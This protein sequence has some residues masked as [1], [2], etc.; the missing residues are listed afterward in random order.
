MRK[1]PKI[2][3]LR[4]YPSA[5]LLTSGPL[6]KVLQ[7]WQSFSEEERKYYFIHYEQKTLGAMKWIS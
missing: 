5:L 1:P 6:P 3:E 7:R 4:T 2:A